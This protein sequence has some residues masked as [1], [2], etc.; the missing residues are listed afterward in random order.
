MSPAK[1]PDQARARS[2]R[3]TALRLLRPHRTGTA[4]L[5]AVSLLVAGS[6]AGALALARALA[7]DHPAARTA[8]ALWAAVSGLGPATAATASACAIAAGAALVLSALRRGSRGPLA[9]RTGN[10]ALVLGLTRGGAARLLAER[11]REVNGVSG[12]RVRVGRRRV[13]VL[14][15]TRM[16]GTSGALRGR[17]E[18]SVRR[19]CEE[20][21]VLS[22]LRVR[23]RV[24]AVGPA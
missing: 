16:R 3:R 19:R 20:L 17:V 11:A 23:A 1:N 10:P 8:D 15:S 18:E 2:A 4:V 6:A 13:R 12:A 14:V 5:C 22:P 21:D 7:P 9:L 24:R